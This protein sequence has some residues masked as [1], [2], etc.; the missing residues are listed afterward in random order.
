MGIA[1]FIGVAA[2][3]VGAFLVA[4]FM[5]ADHLPVEQPAMLSKLEPALEG[6]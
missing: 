4:R 5:P 1:V 6:A 3:L 2:A